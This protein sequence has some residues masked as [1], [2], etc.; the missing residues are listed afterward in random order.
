LP[1]L[2]PSLI[3][4]LHL[5][6]DWET[7]FVSKATAFRG[8]LE[9]VADAGVAHEVRQAASPELLPWLTEPPLGSAW[10]P[11]VVFQPVFAAVDRVGGEDLLR[12]I[13]AASMR[14][15]AMRVMQPLVEGM[16]RLFGASPAAFYQRLPG[17]LANQLKGVEFTVREASERHVL[18]T[19]RY[20]Y[21]QEAPRPGFVYWEGVLQTP[22][23][24]CGG[25][26]A[27][28]ATH[29]GAGNSADTATIQITW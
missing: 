20:A 28:S 19:V 21:L 1:E 11:A 4:G 13:A 8:L 10:M 3:A 15:G 17:I 7:G 23:T 5:R 16:L 25:S 26:V 22:V 9:A 14:Q 2:H 18:M 29:V 6:P 27:G 12:R 24:L